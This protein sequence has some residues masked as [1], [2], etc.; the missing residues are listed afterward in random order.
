MTSWPPR[1]ALHC[2]VVINSGA[3]YLSASPSKFYGAFRADVCYENVALKKSWLLR[4]LSRAEIRTSGE[5]GEKVLIESAV[6][7]KSPFT[8]MLRK[9][10]FWLNL[11]RPIV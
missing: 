3:I 2:R 11:E 7:N 8:N 4:R 6:L 5:P 10:D 1:S 9:P